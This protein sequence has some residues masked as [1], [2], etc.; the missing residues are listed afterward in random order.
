MKIGKERSDGNVENIVLK[1]G[2]DIE[3]QECSRV[4]TFEFIGKFAE[5]L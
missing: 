1:G 5:I 3:L 4:T 2:F